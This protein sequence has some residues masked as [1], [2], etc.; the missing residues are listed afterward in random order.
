[1]ELARALKL[2]SDN[3]DIDPEMFNTAVHSALHDAAIE[4][5]NRLERAN[6]YSTEYGGTWIQLGDVYSSQMEKTRDNATFQWKSAFT[7]GNHCEIDIMVTVLNFGTY[8]HEPSITVKLEDA[9]RQIRYMKDVWFKDNGCSL[10]YNLALD[11]LNSLSKP[12]PLKFDNVCKAD[13]PPKME[14]FYIAFHNDHTPMEIVRSEEYDEIAMKWKRDSN[15]RICTPIITGKLPAVDVEKKLLGKLSEEVTKDNDFMVLAAEFGNFTESVK[16]G[17]QEWA[18]V[19]LRLDDGGEGIYHNEYNGETY[20]TWDA[21]VR[22]AGKIPGWHLPT[23]EEWE[24]LVKFC[25][26]EARKNLSSA[27]AGKN[28]KSTH[29]WN[30]DGNGTDSFGFNGKPSGWCTPGDSRV[31][32][33]G[34]YGNFWSATPDGTSYAYYRY[35]ICNDSIFYERLN[36]RSYGFSV[37]LL[38]DS[39]QQEGK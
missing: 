10:I 27:G 36:A 33:D 16:I 18:T 7:V 21:A 8:S 19:N 26:A 28:L 12:E 11:A 22:V 29:G 3:K 5:R 34:D 13:E 23:R 39:A 38:K 35:L 30:D 32:N 9:E 37:R 31:Y 6:L 15:T 24:K 25:N 4:I 14:W 17:E 1:M 2:I 20:Y